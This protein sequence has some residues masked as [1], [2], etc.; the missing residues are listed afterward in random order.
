ML[1]PDFG[2]SCVKIVQV[3]CYPKLL[4]LQVL[5]ISLVFVYIKGHELG[6]ANSA[7]LV[8]VAW[9]CRSQTLS[10]SS[11]LQALRKRVSR[12]RDTAM[13]WHKVSSHSR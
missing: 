7:Q 5:C 2:Y 6:G 13:L 4:I 3:W 12:G 9:L 8:F 11:L 10:S 1:G